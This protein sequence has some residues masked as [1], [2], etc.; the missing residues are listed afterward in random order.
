M[1]N[2]LADKN[3]LSYTRVSTKDQ[4]D[5]GNS[6]TS[7]K[8]AIL[9]YCNLHQMNIVEFFQEDY[10]AKNFIRPTFTQLKE[11]AKK[12]KGKIDYLLVQKWDRFSRNVGKGLL[13]IETFKNLGIEI[14]CIENWIDYSSPDH[15]VMLSIYLST[16]E[17]ENSKISERTKAGT[18]QALKDGRYVNRQP[19]GYISGKDNLDKTLM[20]PDPLYAYKRLI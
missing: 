18:R 4:K 11:F 16:P 6:L 2:N 20:K 19:V 5:F 10:S 14:N 9:N 15:I 3:V 13:M 1:K 7:Q 17:A 8:N 12:N